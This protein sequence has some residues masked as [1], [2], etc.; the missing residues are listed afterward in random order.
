MSPSDYRAP[1]KPLHLG[2][3]TDEHLG[4]ADSRKGGFGW[5]SQQVARLFQQNP[6][7]GVRPTVLNCMRT[8]GKPGPAEIDGVP[9]IWRGGGRVAPLQ[10]QG[11]HLDLLLFIDYRPNYR[12]AF[13]QK[14]FTP[15]IVWV[16]D[17]WSPVQH[18]D[19]RG[20]RLPGQPGAIPQGI[21]PPNHR[22]MQQ[23][24]TLA[25]LCRR[26]LLFGTTATFLRERIPSAY[27][28]PLLDV[29]LLPNLVD[30]SP[31]GISKSARPSVL[32][33]ARMDP[34]KRPWLFVELA[35]RFPDVDFVVAGRTHFTGA[36]SWQPDKLPTNV[37][38]L[39]HVDGEE[40]R[41]AIASAWVLINTSVHEGLPVSFLE[42]LA[43][44]VP[45]LSTLDPE[46]TA[47]RFGVFVGCHSGDGLASLPALQDGLQRLLS[48]HSW[49][50]SLGGAG[51]AW[52]TG[53]HNRDNFLESFRELCRKAGC[54]VPASA[55]P[56][57]SAA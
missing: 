36:G 15:A 1:E 52:V 56:W 17:P 51:R 33:L 5:A 7:L 35:R 30:L 44:G 42:A 18:Q 39:G 3:V 29:P 38:L 16:R 31:V 32:F 50:E 4:L 25:R 27:A 24:W 19:L 41:R 21:V 11:R 57:A 45:L 49:R 47:S 54:R 2:I 37:R 40:K 23:M 13:L 8:H 9:T 14:P 10:L 26:P 46:K 34:V 22:S 6:D 20:L 55:A 53:L 28:I 12:I 43:C 48:D